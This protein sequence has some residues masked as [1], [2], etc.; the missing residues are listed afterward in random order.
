MIILV[1]SGTVLCMK[2]S[3]INSDRERESERLPVWFGLAMLRVRMGFEWSGVFA[4]E[5]PLISVPVS[6]EARFWFQVRFFKNRLSISDSAFGCLENQCL[7]LNL[8]NWF[9]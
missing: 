2:R 3:W 8:F 9:S 7:L 1:D 4:S 5:G 6:R